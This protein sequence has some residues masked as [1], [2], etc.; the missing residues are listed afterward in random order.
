M[1]VPLLKVYTKS[2]SAPVATRFSATSRSAE[3]L[4]RLSIAVQK[5]ARPY[6][7]T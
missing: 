2:L 7:S 5:L 3:T 6:L 1:F 4:Q